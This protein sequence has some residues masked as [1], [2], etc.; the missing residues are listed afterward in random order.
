M[1]NDHVTSDAASTLAPW[2]G[3]ARTRLLRDGRVVKRSLRCAATQIKTRSHFPE[4][5]TVGRPNSSEPWQESK[6]ERAQLSCI[7]TST[8]CASI[9]SRMPKNKPATH[10]LPP[11]YRN[12]QDGA[13]LTNPMVARRTGLCNQSAKTAKTAL[14]AQSAQRLLA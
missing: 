4:P 7:R 1:S 9:Q 10:K 11:R 13:G 5:S 6:T 12:I 8:S 14:N 3:L 2:L